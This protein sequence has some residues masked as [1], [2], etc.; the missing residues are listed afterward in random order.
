MVFGIA[1]IRSKDDRRE[2]AKSLKRKHGARV[3]NRRCEL[4]AA[5]KSENRHPKS[6]YR[7]A[8]D[9]AACARLST[10]VDS[11]FGLRGFGFG[12]HQSRPRP[13]AVIPGNFHSGAP[14]PFGVHP[15]EVFG[16]REHPE[17]WTP[18][19]KAQA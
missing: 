14:A 17:E 7:K 19:T 16:G 3:S 13:S 6:E 12:P 5:S 9:G 1:I 18:N 10:V 11:D 2:I 4:K 8:L 15:S